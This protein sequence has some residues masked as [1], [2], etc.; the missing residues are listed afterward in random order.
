MEHGN[1]ST[2][3]IR[4]VKKVT[5]TTAMIVSRRVIPFTRNDKKSSIL[6]GLIPLTNK[7]NTQRCQR[8]DSPEKVVFLSQ[9]FMKGR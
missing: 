2:T 1:A 8:D 7:C 9:C 3:V 6:D 4:V 5:R